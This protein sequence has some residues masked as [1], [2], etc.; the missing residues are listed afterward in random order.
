MDEVPV[1]LYI[2]GN[3]TVDSVGA[4]E[5]KYKSTGNEKSF[6]TVVLCVTADG[7]KC[8]PMVIFKRKTIPKEGFPKGIVVK[9]NPSGWMTEEIFIEWLS[10]VWKRRKNSFFNK[11]SILIFDSMTAHITERSKSEANR[12][13]TLAVIPKGLTKKLQ[14]LVLTI[15][16]SF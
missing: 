3:F 10:L 13:S 4:K 12:L 15:N 6:Y 1:S 5:V 11:K 8:D 7:G 2:I 14:P 16:R 9:A